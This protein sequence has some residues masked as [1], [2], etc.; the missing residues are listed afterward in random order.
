MLEPGEGGGMVL[1]MIFFDP[2]ENEISNNI[3]YRLKFH[4]RKGL[5]TSNFKP[6]RTDLKKPGHPIH[7]SKC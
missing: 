1:S 2:C 4:F 6:T 5:A 7:S 3:K